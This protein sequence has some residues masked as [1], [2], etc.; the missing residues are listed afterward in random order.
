M[1]AKCTYNYDGNI[2]EKPKS[3]ERRYVVNFRR[4]TFIKILRL[5]R[6]RRSSSKKM[7]Y[8]V[9]IKKMRDKKWLVE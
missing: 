5:E 1:R 6:Y 3:N 9:N 2:M 4:N 8:E 7:K